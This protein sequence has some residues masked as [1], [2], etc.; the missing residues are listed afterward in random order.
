VHV[1]TIEALTDDLERQRVTAQ[2]AFSDAETK[3]AR[4]LKRANAEGRKN[5][6]AEQ[7]VEL[8]RLTALKRSADDDVRRLE[9]KLEQAREIAAESAEHM[10]AAQDTR[11]TGVRRPTNRDGEY[12]LGG[13]VNVGPGS[14][15][16]S[17][18]DGAGFSFRPG[19]AASA[20]T[21]VRT[22]D[23]RPA[24]VERGQRFADHEIVREHAARQSVADQAVIGQHGSLGHL[25][26]SMTT[27][28]G[29]AI[30][31]QVWAG[32]VIDKA[33]NLSATLRA[34]A[35]IVPMDAKTV[36]IGR[37]ITDPVASFRTEGSTV[38]A[39]DP[40]F[41]A[42]VLSATTMSALVTGSM[43]FFM[44]SPNS[45]SLIS[46]AIAQA[47]ATQ[48]DYVALFG[49]VVAGGE[50]INLA[51]PPNPRGVLATLLA[52]AASSVL[53]SGANGTAQ[54]AA[55]YWREV[56]SAVFLPQ[57]F[58]EQ[59]NA[60]LWNAKLLQQYVDAYDTTQQPLNMPANI[61]ELERYTT[62]QIPSF[63]QGTMTSRATDL[64]VGD[65][66]QLLIG[67]RLDLSIQVL[68]ERYAE[69][70][71][72]GI[73]AHWRGDIALARPRAFCCYRYLQ[74]AL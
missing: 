35:E 25:L 9:G 58:N 42:V 13:G 27:S 70:G 66:R 5:L 69:L 72:I 20:P 7:D 26:R 51:I 73:V 59:P 31:P 53:G 32:D 47:I 39:S 54:T 57:T 17:S 48:L 67:Q 18:G 12:T 3:I 62:N 38:T 16:A 6:T 68:T 45:D 44:D 60:I 15:F 50:G 8:D 22:S 46:D 37:L 74:G 52:V 10:A 4:L 33:R 21:W 71:Q 2:R 34:G 36:N 64:F 30:V 19:R 49:G 28:S 24:T 63:T 1:Q 61:G 65:W 29:S 40:V 23:N 55:S 11:S 14:V 41:D 56:Q 43:E